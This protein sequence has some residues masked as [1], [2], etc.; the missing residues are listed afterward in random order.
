MNTSWM[1]AAIAI[2]IVI[3]SI[4]VVVFMNK[5]MPARPAPHTDDPCLVLQARIEEL[6]NDKR[7]MVR[8]L[9][10]AFADSGVTLGGTIDV[11]QTTSRTYAAFG[12]YEGCRILAV[13]SQC[14]LKNGN[15]TIARIFAEEA[16]KTCGHG[17]SMEKTGS[18]D[19]IINH[20][21]A[22]AGCRTEARP[23]GLLPNTWVL[24]CYCST[25]SR[26]STQSFV[27]T[28]QPG[29]AAFGKAISAQE[30]TE[31]WRCP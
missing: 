13:S 30:A 11:D 5:P 14:A 9:S 27:S 28:E 6:D 12:E 17:S 31:H 15:E 29:S 3:L 24:E 1:R 8:G 19:A 21:D 7:Q 10:A 26:I 18:D 2:S 4:G 16:A 25:S 23:H 20:A 22:S